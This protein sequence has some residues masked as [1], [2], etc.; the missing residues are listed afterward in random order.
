[1]K[2]G[3][4]WIA[5]T[6]LMT[7]SL[8]STS[9]TGSTA[10]ITKSTTQI[11]IPPTSITS[12]AP[13]TIASS[14]PSPTSPSTT[15]AAGHWWDKLGKPQYGGDM[16]LRINRN[17]VNF[18]PYFTAQLTAVENMWLEKL[19]ADD[20]TLDP[21]VFDYRIDFRPPDYIKG[22]LAES[23][24]FT[25]A[26]TFVVHLRKGVNWQNIPPLNGRELTADDVSYHYDRLYGLGHGFSKP[27]PFQA[28]VV[29]FQSLL[30]VTATERY[31]VVFKWKTQNPEV[32]LEALQ[33]SLSNADIAA[34]EAVE[35]WGDVSD[36][37]N[38]IGTGAFILKDFVSSSSATLVKNP[39]YWGYDERYPQNRLPY[40]DTFIYLIIPDDATALAALRTGKIDAMDGLSLQQSRLL[41]KSNPEMLQITAPVANCPSIDPRND[42]APFKDIRVRKAMQMAID[43]P[44]LNKT[45]Y[46]GFS[47]PSPSTLTSNY[48]KGWGWPYNLWPQDLKDEYAYNPTAAKKLLADAG[49]PGGFKTN[50][51]AEATVDMDLLQIVKSYFAAV[52]IDMEIRS[53]DSASWTTFVQVG[54]KQDALAM[55]VVA[56]LGEAYEPMRQ[57][58]R[59]QTG[60]T[61]NWLM[62][63]DPV[64][65]AFYTKANA[66]NSVD[67]IKKVLKDTNEYVARQHIAIS[68]IQNNL[69]SLYQPWFKG[70]NSQNFSISGAS[71]GPHYVGFY[72]A[73]FWIDEKL[74]KSMGK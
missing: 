62:L 23:W 8:V 24:E 36:W 55:R 49:Y 58:S 52:G 56:S 47:D 48:M 27:S 69:F 59:F 25:E 20:W 73:R 22:L 71:G 61:T 66:A 54:H 44:T 41:Q 57:F 60:Y 18:D 34:R 32:I 1:M 35:K 9:C 21:A 30:S 26:G 7:S 68:L 6:V 14:V 46:D 15:T 40:I 51:V 70:Y 38:A 16:I 72:A 63:S 45:Y 31:T 33:G 37:H 67:D 64:F 19:F 4:A 53:M 39:N 28:S 17:I 12:T 10:T 5:L 65:D 43:L 42:L 50:V 3:I 13:K 29:A 11:S 74:K 2:R